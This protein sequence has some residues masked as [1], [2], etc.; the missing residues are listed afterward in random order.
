[1][2]LTRQ[3]EA[4]L[5]GDYGE[6]RAKALEIIV[7]VGEAIGAERLIPV[8]HVH[9]SGISYLNIRE[10]GLE[11]MRRLAEEGG[12]AAVYTTIN[13]ACIDLAGLSRLI[14][15]SPRD[16]Q[17]A[18]NHALEKMGFTPT[19]TCIPYLHRPPAPGEHL[20]WGE[21]NAVVM[22]NSFY[23]AYTN[24]EGGPLTLAAALTG[25]TYYGGLHLLENRVGRFKVRIEWVPSE[26]EYSMIGLWIGENIDTIPVVEFKSPPTY[27][28]LKL[29]YAASAAAGS[30][31]LVVTE[32]VT[33]P[34][35]FSLDITDKVSLTPRDLDKYRMPVN[36]GRLLGY[37]GCPHLHPSELE[38][39]YHMLRSTGRVRVGNALLVSIPLFYREVYGDL[40]GGLRSMGVDIA[41]GT[42]PI[43][44]RI[45]DGFDTVI[46]NSGKAFFYLSRLHGFNVRLASME[47]I[48]RL[49][50]GAGR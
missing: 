6:A 44:S 39:L 35:T 33:P 23:G 3:Q 41:F 18:I 38:S 16:K 37:V 1:M 43:V 30:H 4:I 12:R 2:F 24:R 20:A 45:R 17:L 28:G 11:L 49:V 15:D 25:Y 19:Y 9:V 14:D 31:G 13:P 50:S 32:G 8:V 46:T 47:N 7:K 5:R 48:V 34:G 27:T 40:I 21:S 36:N 10:A 42:C 22:A 29:L 26:E